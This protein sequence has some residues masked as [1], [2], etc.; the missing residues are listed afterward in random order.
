[1]NTSAAL[2]F[3][4][5]LNRNNNR[6]W[7]QQNKKLYDSIRKDYET[8]VAEMISEISMLDPSIGLPDYK[9]CIFRI[10]RDV[11]FSP[12][13][14]PYKTHFGAFVGKGGRKTA[15]V[16]Y[17]IHI[18]PGKSLIAGGVY[19]PQPDVLKQLRNEIYFNSTEF[20]KII[21]DPKF[22]KNF[23]QLDDFDKMKLAP[24][25]FPADFPDIDLLKYRSYIIGRD[26]TDSEVVSADFKMNILAM[27]SAMLPLHDFL[28]RA[29]I[30][31]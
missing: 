8:F 31:G 6:A 12:D 17:Y 11:R 1:M 5:Q 15:G 30:N 25:D 3:L 28:K 22:V 2:D 29:M 10:Y 7:F 24:K 21:T 23:G 16:G 27:F 13:K 19:Q 20:K 9:D 18:E 14:S 26:F 4:S